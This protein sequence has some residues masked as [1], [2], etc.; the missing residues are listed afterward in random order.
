[1][2][3]TSLC[4]VLAL[5]IAPSLVSA[6]A[7]A[8]PKQPLTPA[9]GFYDEKPS[10]STLKVCNTQVI[11]SPAI[12]VEGATVPT[13]KF[14]AY[15]SDDEMTNTL[16]CVPRI[17]MGVRKVKEGNQTYE[18]DFVKTISSSKAVCTF[19]VDEGLVEVSFTKSSIA[20]GG[21][22]TEITG[23]TAIGFTEPF[24]STFKPHKGSCPQ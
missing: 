5:A 10:D 18:V 7:P 6:A 4:A 24:K 12:Q 3:M 1:M 19:N 15:D 23:D 11:A 8:V 9:L 21:L 14:T 13:F 20:Y 2:K 17:T 16:H 22:Y